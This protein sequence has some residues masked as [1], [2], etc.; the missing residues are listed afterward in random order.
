MKQSV[1][2]PVEILLIESVPQNIDSIKRMLNG[3]GS[4]YRLH[5]ENN[6][7]GAFAFMQEQGDNGN[8]KKPD[9]VFLNSNPALGFG[10]QLDREINNKGALVGSPVMFLDI[11][12]GKIQVD[13]TI[14]NHIN[15]RSTENLD[16][17][18]FIET[19]VSLKKFVGSLAKLPEMEMSC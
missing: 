12:N 16:I 3:T 4:K 19:I 6:I 2:N 8:G 18:Y 7:T 10:K 5:V 9:V 13:K 11:T 17:G 15:F 1:A 14:D